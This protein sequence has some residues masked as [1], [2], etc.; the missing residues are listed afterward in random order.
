MATTNDSPPFVGPLAVIL[1]AWIAEQQAMGYHYT[2][3]IHDL[4]RFDQWS[5][6]IGHCTQTLPQFLAEQWTA[7]RP[8]EGEATRQRRVTLLRG[9]AQYMRRQGIPAWI[10]APQAATPH[11]LPHIFTRAELAQLFRA[12]DAC[13]PDSRSPYRHRVF[14]MLFRVLYGTGVRISEAIALT[15]NDFD[16][17]A[18]TIH[19]RHGKGDKERRIPLH[20]VLGAMLRNYM[21]TLPGRDQNDPRV[22]QCPRRFIQGTH[23]VWGF[24]PVFMGGRHFSRW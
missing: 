13:P 20:P 9:L 7:R 8:H 21:T 18:G 1:T 4:R 17:Q 14:P 22:P 5:S 16:A 2:R 10:P 3:Q 19:I 11:Y 23:A 24:P 6:T 12:I 15:R